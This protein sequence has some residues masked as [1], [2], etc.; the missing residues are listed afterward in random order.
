VGLTFNWDTGL[1][2]NDG[3]Y[4]SV[5]K[6]YVN[7][8]NLKNA[9]GP[10]FEDVDGE[11]GP[12][13]QLYCGAPGAIIAGCV[14]YNVFGGPD[15]GVSNGVITAEEQRAM[16]N[17]IGYTQVSTSG[18]T[19]TN[20]YADISSELFEL[21]AGALGVAIGVENRKN[22]YFD[23]PDTL[24]ASGGSSDNFSEPTKGKQTVFEY[25]IE[26]NIPVLKDVVGAQELTLNV[27]NR[28]SEYDANGRVGL[29]SVEAESASPSTTKVSLIWRPIDQLMVRGSWGETFRAPSVVDLYGGQG[30]SFPQATD[31]CSTGNWEFLDDEQ[32]ARCTADSVPDGGW[33]QPTAQL[34]ALI[35]GNPDLT[36]EEG[37]N[38]TVGVVWE[39]TFLDNFSVTV[40]YW[41][42]KIENAIQF[43]GTQST[44]NR[45]YER[46]QELYCALVE[47]APDGA[48][49]AVNS[50]SFNLAERQ[51]SGVD[52]GLR[53]QFD[54]EGFGT[55][56]F[57]WDTTYVLD[58]SFKTAP[59][60]SWIDANGL[61]DGTVHWE[62]RSNLTTT[63][64]LENLSAAW[65][66]R[67]TSELEEDCFYWNVLGYT[68][69]NDGVSEKP[70]LCTNPN[71]RMSN[72]LSGLMGYSPGDVGVNVLGD[73]VYHDLQVSYAAPWNGVITVGGRNIFG[74][75]PP[76]VNNSFAHS[77]DGAYDLPGG[78]YWYASYKQN[79]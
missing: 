4:D 34:R 73:R 3:Q 78:A 26:A 6:N 37:E 30:E 75:E 5:G 77:F 68:N 7:L 79:F 61:Y 65:T 70:M 47:R 16:L 9:L 39:P 54:T 67:Y 72:D 29:E 8:F 35:G 20:W 52:L 64:S 50:T 57:Q 53:Y 18:L 69:P 59:D 71:K 63:W 13:G 2:Y 60:E 23:Q 46:G 44:L 10:S 41:D 38:F 58:D 12:A 25:Y 36:P 11:F 74:R 22:E 31:P 27:A 17:Y 24:V 45:C 76:L 32:R 55:F 15:L 40:D 14:P 42:I 51:A 1:Q 48:V 62:L 49:Q 56:G 19:S 66:M 28:W 21:P 33:D 43:F